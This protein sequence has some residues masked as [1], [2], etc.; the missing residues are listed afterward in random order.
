M[1][2]CLITNLNAYT[3]TLLALAMTSQI[4]LCECIEQE[5]LEVTEGEGK[6]KG[7]RGDGGK[8]CVRGEEKC[9]KSQSSSFPI[10]SLAYHIFC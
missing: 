2:W 9:F 3:F 6:N 10:V 4:M 5:P 8:T 7:A 1:A